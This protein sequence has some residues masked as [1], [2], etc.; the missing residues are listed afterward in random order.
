MKI[1]IDTTNKTIT[2]EEDVNL[3][4]FIE[5]INNLIP[6]GGWREYTLKITKITEWKEPI[7]I[8]RDRDVKPFTQPWT[9][10]NQYP[11]PWT[12]V[13]NIWY[14]TTTTRNTNDTTIRYDDLTNKTNKKFH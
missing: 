8:E 14:G 11:Q 5:G 2:I 12:T 4:D 10:P 13:P 1:Q 9:V 3:H 6:G 7:V